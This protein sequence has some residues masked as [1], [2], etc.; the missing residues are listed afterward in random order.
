[1]KYLYFALFL[2][3]YIF[4][5]AQVPKGIKYQAI[6]RTPSGE[7]VSDQNV[8]FAIS[9]I[10]ASPDQNPVYT[11]THTTKTNNFGLVN[12]VIGNGSAL[13]GDFS[14]VVWSNDDFFISI[15][16]DVNGG[17]DFEWLGTSQLLSVPFAFHAETVTN[18]RVNDEDSSTLN[19][20]QELLI[21]E[22]SIKITHG[23]AVL[24]PRTRYWESTNLNTKSINA[25]SEW[26][27][28]DDY[29]TFEKQN[30]N[31]KIE[32]V[33]NSQFDPGTF[34]ENVRGVQFAIRVDDFNG[35]IQNLGVCQIS[36]IYEF[37]S[38]FSVFHNLAKGPHTASIWARVAG[39]DS[40]DVLV[41]PGG[42]GG[43]MIIKETW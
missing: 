19:E 42:W 23:N 21:A 16:L 6:A 1:M 7:I 2:T 33:V 9:I 43:R 12:L 30:A 37:L 4:S 36:R 31:S 32:I 26:I 14:G 10:P 39:G 41:D 22:D 18:D 28:I 38:L 5:G 27:K 11:E 24:I 15:S 3:L 17:S 13:L 40:K 35:E 20:I 8:S 34:D 29:M 25:T